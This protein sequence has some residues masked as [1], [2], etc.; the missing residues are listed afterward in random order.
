MR[1]LRL[2]HKHRK[3]ELV[4]RVPLFRDSSRREI[5]KIARLADEIEVPAGR[6]LTRE[7]ETGKEFVVL[8]EGAAEVTRG[9]RT[10]NTLRSGDFLG[11]IALVTRAPRTA[12]VTTTEP[13]R[14]LVFSSFMFRE[15]L[16]TAAVERRVLAT[17]AAR[18]PSG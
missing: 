12:T 9:G 18:L 5:E 8:A 14:L 7:G 13:S 2:H 3:V 10:V 17:L 1:A 4:A 16:R 11:E 6:E 15:L